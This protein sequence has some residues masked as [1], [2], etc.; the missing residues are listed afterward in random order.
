MKSFHFNLR[1]RC[2][3]PSLGNHTEMPGIL[4]I[5]YTR[6]AGSA[7]QAVLHALA[8]LRELIPQ[9]YL[10]AVGP[11]LVDFNGV[12]RLFELNNSNMRKLMVKMG[13][14][15]PAPQFIGEKAVWHS[16]DILGL[17]AAQAWRD[18]PEAE[19]ELAHFARSI[20][21]ALQ[22]HASP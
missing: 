22:L 6:Q 14:L 1:Y 21:R 18:I 5:A 13:A 17:I 7:R 2:A 16:A 10:A 9:G 19:L 3:D 8:E 15:F 20:N 11:D 4:S 12:A